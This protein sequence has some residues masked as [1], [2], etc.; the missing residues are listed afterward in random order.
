M[1]WFKHFSNA[2]NDNALTKV[3]MRYGAEGYAIYWYCLE[4]IAADLGN[5]NGNIT[6]ELQHDAEVIAFNLRVDSAKV[7]EIMRYLVSLELFEES[8]SNITCLKLAKFLDKKVTRNKEIH[9]IIDS[10]KGLSPSVGDSLPT[11]NDSPYL[12]TL[13]EIRID[14]KR[15]ITKNGVALA[16]DESLNLKEQKQLCPKTVEQGLWDSY[17]QVRKSKRGVNTVRSF[18]NIYS[19]LFKC[20]E[21]GIEINTALELTVKREWKGIDYDWISNELKKYTPAANE[22]QSARFANEL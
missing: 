4:L 13:D 16:D 12:S 10:S 2:H 1:K 17:L 5:E 7:E 15:L 14:K 20:H 11:K 19:Q 18:K 9:D 22:S 21:N 3:R 6:F 8:N